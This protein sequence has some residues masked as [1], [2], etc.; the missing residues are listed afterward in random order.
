[1][2]LDIEILKGKFITFEGIDGAGKSTQS[3]IFVDHL[4][5]N[6][7]KAVL[8]R[9][10]GGCPE[11]E[12]IRNL[13]ISGAIDKFD[14]MVELLL[15]YAA[16]RAHTEKKIKPLLKDGITVVSDRYLDS[17][18]AYQGFG[19]ELG[20][21]KIENLRKIVLDDFTTDLTIILDLPVEVSLERA[22]SRGKTNRFEEMQVEFYKRVKMGFDYVCET[23]V[24]RCVRIDVMNKNIE[25]VS[26]VVL[27]T[28]VRFFKNMFL[29][30][31]NNN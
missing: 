12:E 17:T 30:L 14:G 16:R 9:E 23:D 13:L 25:E 6:G 26:S 8:T 15:M 20:R 5:E 3:K 31:P 29:G 10:P 7:V 18:L 11:A 4:N 22:N 21:D 28:A 2:S 19:R 27:E 24:R 1:V